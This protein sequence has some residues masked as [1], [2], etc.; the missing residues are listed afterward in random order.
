MPS[1]PNEGGAGLAE[2]AQA[3]RFPGRR[4]H[5]AVRRCR[6]RPSIDRWALDCRQSRF[7]HVTRVSLSHS[8]SVFSPCSAWSAGSCSLALSGPG[9]PLTLIRA[10]VAGERDPGTLAALRHDR[11]H[12]DGDAIARA[13]T[14]PWRAA[15]LFVLQQA[16]AL[17][18]CYTTQRSACD[19]QIARAFSGLAPRCEPAPAEPWPPRPSLPPRTASG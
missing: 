12:K 4:T 15:P 16:L 17:V 13:L 9:K 8:C 10:I 1:P 2:V 19:A 7:R 14:G 3:V 11:C 6:E 5:L 18:A